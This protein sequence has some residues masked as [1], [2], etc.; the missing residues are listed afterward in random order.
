MDSQK[1]KRL[2]RTHLVRITLIGLGLFYL[3]TVNANDERLSE[4]EWNEW[5]ERLFADRPHDLNGSTVMLILMRLH[6]RSYQTIDEVRRA[7]AGFWF[8][9][10]IGTAAHCSGDYLARL[11]AERDKYLAHD[12]RRDVIYK[13]TRRRVIADCY[14]RLI[15]G[16]SQI[17]SLTRVDKD[18]IF[19]LGHLW[20]LKQANE[21]R[22]YERSNLGRFMSEMIIPQARREKSYFVVFWRN[23]VCGHVLSRL[24]EEE[25]RIQSFL[26][27]LDHRTDKGASA[28]GINW[29]KG[30]EACKRLLPQK[31]L[32]EVWR[33]AQM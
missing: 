10:N 3:R 29:V 13:F 2:F 19:R 23:G 33:W 4:K 7:I 30:L 25:L 18:N 20:S 12:Y 32:D 31:E 24:T 22:K 28:M 16:I 6:K 14:A 8:E 5:F 1:A 21:G 26:A 15:N 17:D 27:T 11:D 9:A